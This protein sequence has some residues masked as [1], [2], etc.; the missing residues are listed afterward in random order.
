MIQ[1]AISVYRSCLELHTNHTN[2]P[3]GVYELTIGKH[4]CVM[5]SVLGC[6]GG[7]WTLAMK[8]DGNLVSNIY[9]SD[10]SMLKALPYY[11]I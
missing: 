3:D 7:G 5:Q 9:A 10:Q 6:T 8:I 4:F 11:M 2:A 1:S